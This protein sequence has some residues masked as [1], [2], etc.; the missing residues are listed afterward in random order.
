MVEYALVHSKMILKTVNQ[1]DLFGSMSFPRSAHAM[2]KTA[3]ARGQMSKF[4]CWRRCQ[5][6]YLLRKVRSQTRL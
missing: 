4:S 6:K 1:F 2:R 5:N 3:R